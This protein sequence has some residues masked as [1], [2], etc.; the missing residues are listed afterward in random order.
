MLSLKE[1]PPR[2]PLVRPTPL[3]SLTDMLKAQ[4]NSRVDSVRRRR[5]RRRGHSRR[6][7]RTPSSPTPSPLFLPSPSLFCPSCLQ[8]V[9]VSRS[10]HFLV[11]ATLPHGSPCSLSQVG[12]G[13]A[14]ARREE[15]ELQARAQTLE[16]AIAAAASSDVLAAFDPW[17]SFTD[18]KVG[19]HVRH[20]GQ[21][22]KCLVDHGST[23]LNPPGVAPTDASHGTGGD[24]G[25][26]K[27]STAGGTE[28]WKC[29]MS[30]EQLQAAKDA[31]TAPASAAAGGG[32]GGGGGAAAAAAAPA[33]GQA[34]PLTRSQRKRLVAELR[35]LHR[36]PHPACD[37]YPTEVRCVVDGQVDGWVFAACVSVIVASANVSPRQALAQLHS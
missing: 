37:V 35:R 30:P 32:G 15:A 17:E 23:E 22:Y 31:L 21:A 3:R 12:T 34:E 24:G 7:H 4:R 27:A 19:T 8:C 26:A 6:R 9:D 36:E 18:Y 28:L 20:L 33:A 29:V 2:P 25:G 5:L 14:P 13:V 10:K 11:R 1:R 16:Q